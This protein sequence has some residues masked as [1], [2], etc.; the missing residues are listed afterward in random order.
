M[1]WLWNA[2]GMVME[3]L[4]DGWIILDYD[5][6]NFQQ[7][8]QLILCIRLC[9]PQKNWLE[10]NFDELGCYGMKFSSGLSWSRFLNSTPAKESKPNS[11]NGVERSKSSEPK[12]S[13][14]AETTRV[15]T[16]S[17]V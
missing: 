11:I 13:A 17:K 16:S 15:F 14:K 1:E 3:W 10:L 9:I 6:W 5:L 4:W 2:Y 12:A 7:I 8:L